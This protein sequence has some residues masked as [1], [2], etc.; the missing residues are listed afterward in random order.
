VPIF[1]TE[2]CHSTWSTLAHPTV[3]ASCTCNLVDLPG[4]AS[5]Q[6]ALKTLSCSSHI[7][8][9]DCRA[10]SFIGPIMLRIA[11]VL[12]AFS[13]AISAQAQPARPP[14]DAPAKTVVKKSA[15]PKG[16]P[17]SRP[18][19]P[20]TSGRCIG[21][22]SVIGD[23]FAVK[24]IGF[25]VFGNEFKEIPADNLRLDDLVVERVQAAVGPGL[26]ARKIAHPKGAFDSYRTGGWGTN[27][28]KSSALVEQVAGPARCERYLVVTRATAQFS[29][30]QDIIGVGIVNTGAA[31][32]SRSHIH[33]LVHLGLHDGRTFAVLKSGG[34]FAPTRQLDDFS[35]PES[36][37]AV[38]TPVVRAAARALLAEALDKRLPALLAP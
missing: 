20:P 7:D 31:L 21:V 30:N 15:A 26:A 3:A 17:A 6:L 19:P 1:S 32:L 33:A 24:K 28:A 29:G 13:V 4:H 8:D 9:I 12:L 2:A 38:N 5:T 10:A 23:R 35:W 22:I 25:T 27:D 34:A 14:A 11:A 36:P 18:A 37:E 16:T